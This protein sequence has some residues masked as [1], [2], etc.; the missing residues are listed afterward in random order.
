MHSRRHPSH[1]H[2]HTRTLQYIKNRWYHTRLKRFPDKQKHT[3][4]ITHYHNVRKLVILKHTFFFASLQA[5]NIRSG[6]GTDKCHSFGEKD[7]RSSAVK[8]TT[9]GQVSYTGRGDQS[10]TKVTERGGHC[11]QQLKKTSVRCWMATVSVC[12]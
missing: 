3:V 10:V 8:N 2:T 11:T 4:R 12:L 9:S 7:T 5:Q 6:S 1:T